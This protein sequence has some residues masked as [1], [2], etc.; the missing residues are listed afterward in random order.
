M[1]SLRKF[2]CASESEITPAALT[3]MQYF[4]IFSFLNANK[5]HDNVRD[6][7]YE[8]VKI[9]FKKIYQRE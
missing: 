5:E 9:E 7:I 8:M 6:V 3:Q 2:S 1:S 4:H